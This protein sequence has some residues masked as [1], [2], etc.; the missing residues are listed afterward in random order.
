MSNLFLILY[1]GTSLLLIC[2]TKLKTYVRKR[3]LRFLLSDYSSTYEGLLEKSS[4][5]IMNLRRQRTLSREILN[6][7]NP[8]YTN[9][10]TD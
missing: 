1:C 6:K 9:E 4:C 3:A 5:P 10:Q 2:Q 8:G 7:I